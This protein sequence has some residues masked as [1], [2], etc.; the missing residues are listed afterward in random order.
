MKPALAQVS[1]LSG[2]FEKDVEDYAAAKCP[3]IELWLGK[4][5]GYLEQHSI[6]DVR[7]LLDR[8][9]IAAPV[10]SY[11]GGLLLS[12]G[13]ARREHW[14]HFQQR[15]ELCRQLGAETIVLAGDLNGPLNH[16]DLAQARRALHEAGRQA[17]E[18]GIRAAVEFQCR[19][20]FANNLQSAAWLVEEVAEP[21]LGLCFDLFHY[22]CGPSKAEDLRLLNRENLFHVQLC[23]LAGVP[24]ELAGD[25]DR[26][27]PGDGDIALGPI[28]DRLREIGYQEYVSIEVMNPIL[29][30]VPPRQFAEIA[31][32][33]LRVVLGL[34]SST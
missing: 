17:G 28:L 8:H 18:A 12:Q 16:E 2:P 33:S 34:S 24:R 7:R 4:L 29:W 19:A 21:N 10:A 6:D 14:R 20:T 31:I 27:L 25:G 26:V 3:A 11:Q 32:T 23:D 13:A 9:E 22:Y 5:E 30:Q 15:L 1:S